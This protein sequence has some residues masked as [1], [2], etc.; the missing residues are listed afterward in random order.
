MN[1]EANLSI[2]NLFSGN[3]NGFAIYFNTKGPDYIEYKTGSVSG[4]NT[5]NGNEYVYSYSNED[6]NN[7]VY[8]VTVNDN[9]FSL[10]IGVNEVFNNVFNN[11][12]PPAATPKTHCSFFAR[13][14]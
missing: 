6:D 11:I 14:D 8:E 7:Q 12:T 1:S 9:N 5:D 10:K 3:T 13:T 2:D 4:K